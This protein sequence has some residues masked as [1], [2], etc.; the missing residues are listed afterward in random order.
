[1]T[2]A[3]ESAT[4]FRP[5][6]RSAVGAF[7]CEALATAEAAPCVAMLIDDGVDELCA[8]R[9]IAELARAGV[10]VSLLAPEIAPIGTQ[11]GGMLTPDHTL[12]ELS[13]DHFDAVVIPS[14]AQAAVTLL[15]SAATRRFVREAH[16]LGLPLA[17]AGD[18]VKLLGAIGVAPAELGELDEPVPGLLVGHG[19][20]DTLAAFGRRLGELVAEQPHR[21]RHAGHRVHRHA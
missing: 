1:M 14:G 13:A 5:L 4:A 9:L 8:A 20:H 10:R 3:R 16:C 11:L 21:P 19:A 17:A 6:P 7:A 18:G 15:Q 12:S 2:L